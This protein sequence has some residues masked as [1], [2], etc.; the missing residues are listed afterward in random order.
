MKTIFKTS[1]YIENFHINNYN[2]KVVI[3]KKLI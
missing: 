1:L 2:I 3:K